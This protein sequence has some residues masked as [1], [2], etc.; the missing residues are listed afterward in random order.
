MTQSFQDLQ[1]RVLTLAKNFPHQWDKKTHFVDLVEE[2]GELANALL[3]EGKDKDQKRKRAEINDSL[4]DILFE[5]IQLADACDVDLLEVL[6]K[7]LDELEIRQ[8][9]RE[10][11]DD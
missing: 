6:S 8:N 9:N 10:Y 2:V 3:I 11:H 5:L 7:Q 4:A 1:H